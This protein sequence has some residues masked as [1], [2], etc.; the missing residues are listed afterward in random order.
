MLGAMVAPGADGASVDARSSSPLAAR[1]GIAGVAVA[2]GSGPGVARPVFLFFLLFFS[3][4]FSSASLKRKRGNEVRGRVRRKV[5]IFVQG[6]SRGVPLH[7]SSFARE[8]GRWWRGHGR[9]ARRLLPS[10]G[11]GLGS[12]AGAFIVELGTALHLQAGSAP[13]LLQVSRGGCVGFSS[14]GLV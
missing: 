13:L 8:E 3:S 10:G 9:F 14:G 4:F 12:L 1:G 6:H 7:P 5:R 2:A 11:P